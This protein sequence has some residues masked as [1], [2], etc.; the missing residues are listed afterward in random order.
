V[1]PPLAVNVIELPEQTA[2][3]VGDTVTTGL[4]EILTMAT[5]VSVQLPV[6]PVTVYV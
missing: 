2:A 6:V 1:L 4:L 5:D 3:L